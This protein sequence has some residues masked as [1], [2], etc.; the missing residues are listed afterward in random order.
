M[1]KLYLVLT[2][3]SADGVR[4]LAG[5]STAHELLTSDQ[6]SVEGAL[7]MAM[8]VGLS[9]G[10]AATAAASGHWA[11]DVLCSAVGLVGAAVWIGLW[12]RL[13]RCVRVG[14]SWARVMTRSAVHAPALRESRAHPSILKARSPPAQCEGCDNDA[15]C[16]RRLEQRAESALLGRPPRRPHAV[17]PSWRMVAKEGLRYLA[18]SRGRLRRRTRGRSREARALLCSRGVDGRSRRR[19][20]GYLSM[21]E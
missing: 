10:S 13:A 4:L 9:L 5:L 7:N 16:R 19:R 8:A 21:L 20:L 6:S 2:T 18:A 14:T 11:R 3:L 17:S 1:W 15:A 12:S